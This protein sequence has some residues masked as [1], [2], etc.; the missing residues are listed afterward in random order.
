LFPPELP[1]Y[2]KVPPTTSRPLS[3]RSSSVTFAP[4]PLDTQSIDTHPVHDVADDTEVHF[5]RVSGFTS[6]ITSTSTLS[7]PVNDL[8]NTIGK[9][10]R[11]AF[12]KDELPT[13]ISAM[14]DQKFGKENLSQCFLAEPCL[15]HVLAP[16]VTSSFLSP[17]DLSNLQEALP[18]ARTYASLLTEFR[19]VDFRPL[20]NYSPNWQGASTINASLVQMATAALLH[21]EG[22]AAALVRWIGGPHVGE[23]RNIPAT[24]KF[25]SGKIDQHLV[26]DLRRIF[27]DGIPT[28]CNASASESNFQSFVAY[29]N[30]KT[31]SEDPAQTYKSL[32]K[33]HSRGYCLLFDE[34]ILPFVLNCHLTPG[35]L[36]NINHPYKPVRPIFDSTFRPDH[37]SFAINDWTSKTTEPDVIF[38]RS[39]EKL[40]FWIYNM[41]ITYP[42]AEI[43]GLDDDVSGAFR[44]TKYH[45]NLVA[46][47]SYTRCGFLAM[48]TGGTFG[49]N[50]TPSNWESI[51]RSRQQLARYLWHEPD[52][53]EQAA[54]YL[55]DL[56]FAPPPT[57]ADIAQ[58]AIAESDSLNPGILNSDGQRLPP[59][60]DHHVDD[61]LYAEVADHTRRSVAASMLALF[62]ILGFPEETRAPNPFSMEK[63][64][65]NM[66]HLRKF[67][68]HHIDTRRLIVGILPH[69]RVQAITLLSDWLTKKDFDLRELAGLH[70]LLESLT[71]Y[72]LWAR[73]WFFA[74]QNAIRHEI[75]RRYH[76]V[77]RFWDSSKKAHR[78][79]AQIPKNL[80]HR[81]DAIIARDKA[82]LIWNSR[83]RISMTPHIR[84]C[85]TFIHNHLADSTNLWE[86]PIGF[87]VKRVPHLISIGDASKLAGG[88]HCAR[89]CFWFDVFWSPKVRHAVT[90]L[91]PSDPGYVH[92]N[93]LEFV[94]VVLQLAAVVTR[95]RTLSP[96]QKQAFFPSGLPAHPILLVRSDNTASVAW[97]NK[98][99][100]KSLQGQALIA[101]YAEILRLSN[102]GLSS[103]HIEGVSNIRA[104]DLSRPSSPDLSPS[105]HHA[106]IFQKHALLKTWDY[107]HPSP[108]LLQLLSFSLC[109]GPSPDPP[110]LP[111]IWGR[112]APAGSIISCF[113]EI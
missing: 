98:V 80:H 62:H 54:P 35:G 107:F 25:L 101:I 93:S 61:N 7:H 24:I 29:G 106:Q 89:L 55:P 13:R 56:Q 82:Q 76:V 111:K 18:E 39:F 71:R 84:A 17:S 97:A 67:V 38:A 105:D 104:D 37:Q 41:R 68:G 19:D 33:D 53:L 52:L 78:L 36:V 45:P 31:V 109:T 103:N 9:Q 47:H 92:I 16:L 100:S 87:L 48:A 40:L 11:E 112:F 51:A 6:P 79:K 20:K 10:E 26:E 49:D 77:K 94:I 34:R 15:R 12:V 21:F 60:Y 91:K 69:K 74:F 110:K 5:P 70:G 86:Q 8:K 66:S 2:A 72:M 81:L 58:F 90:A 85:V 30:H 50:T 75:S 28:V 43:Y 108:E 95:L 42:T 96:I 113:S 4:L 27:T 57:A 46:M 3:N 83:V 44:H 63:F 32:L 65:A 88:A 14:L 22:D 64:D 59:Q 1:F 99:T 102:I 73:P 23:H